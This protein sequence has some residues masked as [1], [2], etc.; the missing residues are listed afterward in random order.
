[1]A[2]KN[3]AEDGS[4][5]AIGDTGTTA[6]GAQFIAPAAPSA[7]EP[8]GS[9]SKQEWVQGTLFPALERTPERQA[10][11][12]TSSVP[13]LGVT[14]TPEDLAGWDHATRLGYPGEYPYTR[15]IQPTM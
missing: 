10:R 7:P 12:E 14:Y 11:F 4:P 6:V 2:V 5:G 1:M 13:D 9:H 15:G 8:H 3:Q